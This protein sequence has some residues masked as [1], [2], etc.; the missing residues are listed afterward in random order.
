MAQAIKNVPAKIDLAPIETLEVTVVDVPAS[1]ERAP[2]AVTVHAARLALVTQEGKLENL[3]GTYAVAVYQLLKSHNGK[4]SGPELKGELKK[5]YQAERKTF[6]KL[7][8]S[9]NLSHAPQRWDKVVECMQGMRGGTH[10]P[11]T[12]KPLVD[13][14]KGNGKN[15]GKGKP[16]ARELTKR[17]GDEL[18]KLWKAYMAD[19]TSELTAELTAVAD[20]I[21]TLQIKLEPARA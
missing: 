14:R 10:N 15:K 18:T 8:E 21:E 9:R 19:D 16:A 12:G 2:K 17:A 6:I 4:I 3:R 7:C 13:K 11:D 1:W 5:V 20:A